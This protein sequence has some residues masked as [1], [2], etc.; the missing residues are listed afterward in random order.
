[1]PFSLRPGAVDVHAHWLPESLFGLPPG[2]PYSPL[3]DRDGQLY[4]G[5]IPLSIE[6]RLMSDVDAIRADMQRTG[7][8]ARVL[9][10][11]PFAFAREDHPEASAYVGAFNAALLSVV[12]GSDGAFAGFGCVSLGDVQAARRQMEQLSLAEGIFG[13]AL[14]PVMGDTSLD[15]GNLKRILTLADELELAVLV[16]PMQLPGPAWS[17]HYLTN[18]I[19]NPVETAT[20]IA[21]VLLGGTMERLPELRICFVHGGGCAP[22]LLGRWDH[23]WSLRADVSA[24]STR[25]P[26]ETFRRLFFDT[27]THDTDAL[28][29]LRRKAPDDHI[30]LGS[31]YP[32]DMADTDALTHALE[33]GLTKDGLSQ[34]TRLFLGL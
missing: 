19:G 33:R 5:D 32:F 10:A 16:H 28:D 27:V 23:A 13:V 2:A 20:A 8:A 21:S 7:I 11:P 31:D 14:P 26:S 18:L 25:R 9:S 3:A 12:G 6:S 15:T 17:R 4:I 30:V 22:D 24:D 34:A 29:L 1:M